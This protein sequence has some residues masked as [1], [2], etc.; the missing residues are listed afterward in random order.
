MGIREGNPVWE[1][2]REGSLCRSSAA[3]KMWQRLALVA[4]ALSRFPRCA[5]L[6]M[7]VSSAND[8]RDVGPTERAVRG[9]EILRPLRSL[10]EHAAYD[11]RMVAAR[12]LVASG[13]GGARTAR[14]LTAV[15]E[16]VSAVD[17]KEVEVAMRRRSRKS[18]GRAIG[19]A[20]S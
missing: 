10:L 8:A 20:R 2:N 5:I 14:G 13:G 12:R 6:A 19:D 18:F 16:R 17:L 1:R 15:E 3:W 11:D 9:E 7:V 4:I